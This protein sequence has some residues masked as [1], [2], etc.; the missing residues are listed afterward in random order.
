VWGNGLNEV[1]DDEIGEH[2]FETLYL[3]G[4]PV[5]RSA[6]DPINGWQ[7]VQHWFQPMITTSGEQPALIV[8]PEC[9]T[10]IRT[11]PQLLQA[12]V[13]P[14]QLDDDGPT[15]A[16]KALRYLVMS[17]PEPPGIAPKPE[18]RDLSQLDERTRREIEYLRNVDREEPREV[19]AY[20]LG[21]FWGTT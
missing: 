17:R 16:A 7:R 21:D 20:S 1:K 3:H 18:G 11:L 12:S 13:N 4:V 5:I 19:P 9:S 14:E 15:H 6:H 8:S 2:T 10:L